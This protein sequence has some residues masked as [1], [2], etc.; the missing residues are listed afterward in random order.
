M[1]IIYII[2][3]STVSGNVLCTNFLESPMDNSIA[4][5][6]VKILVRVSEKYDECVVDMLNP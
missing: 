3:L 5:K 1:V 4:A 2:I 6:L